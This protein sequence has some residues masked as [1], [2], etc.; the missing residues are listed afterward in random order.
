MNQRLKYKRM[1]KIVD[2]NGTLFLISFNWQGLFRLRDRSQH[3]IDVCA[4]VIP[5]H[6]FKPFEVPGAQHV[7]YGRFI[8]I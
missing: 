3:P 1:T 2:K 8:E 6:V 4:R 5:G 7:A